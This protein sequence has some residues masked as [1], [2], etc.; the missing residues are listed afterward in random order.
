MSLFVYPAV[1]INTTDLA[2]ETKQDLILAELSL[3]ILDFMDTP[4]LDASSTNI[5]ASATTPVT[6]V[7][8]LASD[9]KAIKINDTMGL[10]VGIYSDPAGTPVLEAI[11]GPGDDQTVQIQ[12]A[13]ATVIGLR[14][15]ANSTIAIG[16]L[17]L[18]FLG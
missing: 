4:V 8:S 9:I 10:Y 6:V 13:S 2:T 11:I 1:P 14:N 15:M 18:Q 5:P 3:D 17:S 12:L 16:E 7:A